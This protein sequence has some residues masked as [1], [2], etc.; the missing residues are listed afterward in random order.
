[1]RYLRY[2][3]ITLFLFALAFMGAGWYL[4]QKYSDKIQKVVLE[5][6]NNSLNAKVSV[7]AIEFSSFKKIPF[8]SL[9]F[10]GVLIKESNDF[11]TNPDTLLYAE[12][13]SFQFV[14]LVLQLF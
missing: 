9:S 14:N 13:L 7:E 11:S 8:L 1:M 2:I 12:N 10:S 3:F 4:S 5:E 6:L